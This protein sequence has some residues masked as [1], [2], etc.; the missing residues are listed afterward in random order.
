MWNRALV[1]LE[2]PLR[3]ELEEELAAL[4]VDEKRRVPSSKRHQKIEI[5]ETISPR[6]M[7]T[8]TIQTMI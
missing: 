7:A 1:I 2:S 6:T 8:T 4:G 3:V 5:T